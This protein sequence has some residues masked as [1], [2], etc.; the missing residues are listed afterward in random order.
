MAVSA[1]VLQKEFT[2]GVRSE[3]IAQLTARQRSLHDLRVLL[4]ESTKQLVAYRSDKAYGGDAYP[5]EIAKLNAV[6]ES[7]RAPSDVVETALAS[8]REKYN[9]EP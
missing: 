8:L 3:L 5:G 9:L 6:L 7:Y 4:D 1:P 2:R